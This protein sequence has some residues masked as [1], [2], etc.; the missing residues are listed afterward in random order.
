MSARQHL[1][2]A[3]AALL[4]LAGSSALACAMCLSAFQVR[5]SA[6]EL[7]YAQR[8]VLVRPEGDALRVVEVVKG[9]VAANTLIAEHAARVDAKA[10]ASTKPLLL[11]REDRW[12][13]WVNMGAI[14][15]EHAPWLRQL[16]AFPSRSE[17]SEAQQAA[18]AAL[19]L[20][21]LES[22]DAM[23]AEIAYGEL[24]SGHYD[25]LRAN[26]AT[27]PVTEL[28]RWL[29]DPALAQRQ[30]LYLLLLGLAGDAR[31]ADA[32]ERRL[33]A[34]RAN[35]D[36]THLASLLAADL[37]L[38]GPARLAWVAQ[39]YLRDPQRSL[40]EQRAAVLA[41][42]ELGGDDATLPRTQVVALYR[43]LIAQRQA[44]AGLAARDL[45]DWG[46]WDL[47][48]AYRALLKSGV[49]LSPP[50]R[51]AIEEY[52]QRSAQSQAVELTLPTPTKEGTAGALL[53]QRKP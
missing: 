18:L 20:P 16:A 17:A 46:V 12:V 33:D 32:I 3:A 31:D 48:P 13:Q 44:A 25:A 49:A 29:A 38:R 7:A 45:A 14:G 9:D 21:A 36:A 10:L 34:M 5:M 27:I 43:T 11:I 37:E 52:L 6:Q 24:A 8:I 51:L 42:A 50:A 35:H 19:L 22:P 2:L 53:A 39:R 40:D 23:V 26:R 1:R 41:L 47:A 4:A 15:A 28:R 30:D